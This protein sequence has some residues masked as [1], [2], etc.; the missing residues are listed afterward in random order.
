[1]ASMDRSLFRGTSYPALSSHDT[2]QWA[3][4]GTYRA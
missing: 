1:M 4:L 2:E 3:D